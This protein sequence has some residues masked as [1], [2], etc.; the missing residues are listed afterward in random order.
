MTVPNKSADRLNRVQIQTMLRPMKFHLPRF[1][2]HPTAADILGGVALAGLVA[3]TF[4]IL[5]Q[6]VP[7]HSIPIWML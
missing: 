2:V 3:W 1:N 7:Y 6:M 5:L 4:W